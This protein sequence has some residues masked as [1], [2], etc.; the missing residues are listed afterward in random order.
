RIVLM[1]NRLLEFDV[2]V[3]LWGRR[4]GCESCKPLAQRG[5]VMADRSRLLAKQTKPGGHHRNA[6]RAVELVV[7]GGADDDIGFRIGFGADAARPPPRLVK[8]AGAWR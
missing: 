7:E 4:H 6:D 1:G 5:L 8:A 3:L 2:V